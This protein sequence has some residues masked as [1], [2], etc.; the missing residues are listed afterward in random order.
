MVLA[1]HARTELVGYIHVDRSFFGVL[2]VDEYLTPSG[3]LRR[4]LK[5]GRIIHGLQF[6]DPELARVPTSYYGAGSG[7][8][9]AINHHPR[10]LMSQPMKLGFVGLGAGTLASYATARDSVRFYEINPDVVALST[11]PTP[12][13][14]YLRDCLGTVEIA[15]GDARIN[16]E[17]EPAQQ[18]QVLVLDAFS[19]DA[20]PA[21]LLTLEAGLL[22]LRHL[23]ED[24]I[25]AIHISNRHL[26]LDPVVRGLADALGLVV[27]RID[28]NE[29]NDLVSRS[30]WMLLARKGSVLAAPE[31]QRAASKPPATK[32]V[33]LLW[34]DTFSNLLQVFKG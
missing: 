34:T 18:F 11:G 10:R 7:V 4:R 3:K 5:H 15:L 21:H 20:I 27:V 23:T 26:D 30:D 16:L 17:R 8:G 2:R 31:I 33:H 13:F 19:S 9:L 14:T 1:Y 28:N 6:T 29:S 25:L 32:R 24:G 12:I 22:Y